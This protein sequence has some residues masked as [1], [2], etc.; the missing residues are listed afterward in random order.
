MNK[1]SHYTDGTDAW[2]DEGA[3]IWG[4][5]H[6]DKY[7]RADAGVSILGGN[8]QTRA[9]TQFGVLHPAEGPDAFPNKLGFSMEKMT[10]ERS[11]RAPTKT[12]EDGKILELTIAGEPVEVAPNR[13]DV[14]DSVGF[15]FPD[16]KALVTN[17]VGI[18]FIFKRNGRSLLWGNDPLRI[19][20]RQSPRSRASWRGHRYQRFLKP[21]MMNCTM[22]QKRWTIAVYT[23]K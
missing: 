18:S 12:F 2:L 10:G 8:F 3:E 16:R 4:H 9:A 1:S 21:W 6:L 13:T 22:W 7:K 11:Y 15:Y 17:A 23:E 14:Q 19:G 20:T 5:E